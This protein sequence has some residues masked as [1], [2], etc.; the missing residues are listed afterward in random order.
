[1]GGAVGL[2]VL[3]A[4]LFFIFRKRR[5]NARSNVHQGPG[6]SELHG[7]TAEKQP[8]EVW[9]QPAEVW[10]QPQELP[11]QRQPVWELS[12]NP[13]TPRVV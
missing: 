10:T 2:L 8:V 5:Q 3:I 9:T 11:S 4:I 12:A 6:I 13:N 1:M 7:T